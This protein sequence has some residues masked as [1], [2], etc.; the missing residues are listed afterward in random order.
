MFKRRRKNG[1]LLGEAGLA[2]LGAWLAAWLLD[3]L[4]ER[5]PVDKSAVVTL[6]GSYNSSRVEDPAIR[7]GHLSYPRGC[8]SWMTATDSACSVRKPMSP[9]KK[10]L[11]PNMLVFEWRLARPTE[12]ETA[13]W[14]KGRSG[15]AE[16]SAGTESPIL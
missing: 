3:C 13:L 12:A 6:S 11:I 1:S 2:C 15:W 4:S 9:Q 10:I 16:A 8:V 5:G 7:P 14:S